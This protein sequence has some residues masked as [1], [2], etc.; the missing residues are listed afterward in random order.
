VECGHVVAALVRPESM[1]GPLPHPAV[2]T[3]TGTLATPPW[4]DLVRFSP[5]TCVHTAW[6]TSAGVY[7]ASPEN[8]RYLDDSLAFV[9]GLFE[10]GVGRVVAVGTAAEYRPS[11]QPLHEA[12]SPIEPRSPYARAKHELRLR[13]SDHAHRASAQLIWA[14]LFQPYGVGEPAARLCSTVARRVA[15]GER[16]T[17]DTPDAVRDWIHVDDVGA[18]L[19]RLVDVRTETVVNVGTGVG[20]TVLEV[21]VTIAGLL[22]RRELVAAATA[23]SDGFGPLVADPMRLRSLGWAPRVELEAG[24][25]ALI[26]GLR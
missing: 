14:R 19:L 21:A 7:L 6:I 20:H 22:G 26:E 23:P 18:A 5:D 9:T 17:L 24:L 2:A 12:R 25:A 1:P 15:A 4:D 8:Q 10:R 16:V 13:L 11:A 3:M